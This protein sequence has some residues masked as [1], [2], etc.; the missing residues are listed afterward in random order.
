MPS[1]KLDAL[2]A[3]VR[4]DVHAGAAEITRLAIA[5]F[6]QVVEGA[7]GVQTLR[8]ELERLAV[9]LIEAQPA[10]APLL[11]LA[12]D[13]LEAPEEETALAPARALVH[14]AL[15]AFRERLHAAPAE[16]AERAEV[17]IPLG[18]SVLTVSASSTVRATL[19]EAARRR[20]FSVTC[21]ES[22]PN[23]EGRA[24]A[25]SLA[26][27]GLDVTFAV[28]AAITSLV[29]GCDVVLVG[30]DSIGDLGI[31]NKIGTRLAALAARGCGIP[32]Y[33]LTDTSK[34]L[35][36]GF[37]Q[38]VEDDR[39]A[40]EV[41][42]NAPAGIRVWNRYFEA[43]PLAFFEGIVTERGLHGLDEVEQMR[44]RIRL[45]TVLAKHWMVG[46]TNAPSE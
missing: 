7:T 32:T 4:E 25:E 2:V 43:T 13:V 22:R 31:V 5:A 24:L 16:V 38:R 45:P 10:M 3:P 19:L 27:A 30:A 46:K 44:E 34:L 23:L 26:R 29:R 39:S 20:T 28:D 21:F 42:R 14:Q 17:L 6:E 33:A 40:D 35:P 11:R 9:S 12:A 15:D 1:M 8:A 37:A 36:P 18:G 41:W